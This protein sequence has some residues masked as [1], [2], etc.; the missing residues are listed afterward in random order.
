MLVC[1]AREAKW[2]N[3]IACDFSHK[4]KTNPWI[5]FCW[6]FFILQV[7]TITA[8]QLISVN[9]CWD[10]IC[11]LS[12]T[13]KNSSKS[14]A[15]TSN[16]PYSKWKYSSFFYNCLLYNGNICSAHLH[17]CSC[18][19]HL[20]PSSQHVSKRQVYKLY[21]STHNKSKN[22]LQTTLNCFSNALNAL[23]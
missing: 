20:P 3:K 18:S 13:E 5:E 10:F 12:S 21:F 14:I 19:F 8:M 16:K 22:N 9:L 11:Q 17:Y 2:I 1:L 15:E 6:F 23:F 7:S 4:N